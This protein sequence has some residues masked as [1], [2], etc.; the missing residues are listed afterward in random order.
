VVPLPFSSMAVLGADGRVFPPGYELEA[1]SD[2]ADA[3]DLAHAPQHGCVVTRAGRARCFGGNGWAQLGDG[4]STAR[5]HVVD[6]D[7]ITHAHGI[8]VLPSLSCALQG[9]DISCWGTLA[10]GPDEQHVA[11]RNAVSV[12]VDPGQTCATTSSGENLCWGRMG[13]APFESDPRGIFASSRPQPLPFKL[14]TLRELDSNCWQ[15]ELGVRVCGTMHES[16]GEEV[17]TVS[18]DFTEISRDTDLIW[19]GRCV[20]LGNALNCAGDAAVALPELR[21]PSALSYDGT[22]V[23]VI[24]AGGKVGCTQRGG[25]RRTQKFIKLAEVPDLDS[26]RQ[27]LGIGPNLY[28]ALDR[29]GDVWVWRIR[30]E[31]Q[32]SSVERLPPPMTGI[33]KIFVDREG[34]CALASSGEVLCLDSSDDSITVRWTDVVDADGCQEHQCVVQRDGL[35]T[36]T[37]DNRFGQLGALP[38]TAIAQRTAIEFVAE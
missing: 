8:A 4:T 33:T 16:D 34:M 7:G 26:A 18:M 28:A 35:L 6:V 15:D 31:G 11:L 12:V 21:R 32:I 22:R 37:G 36:C 25:I 30:S 19:S 1:R 27:L 24:H 29:H 5:E 13:H 10:S 9:R 2:I 20:L 14:G 38:Q 17:A 23:C 3:I